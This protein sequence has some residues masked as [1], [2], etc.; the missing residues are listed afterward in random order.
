MGGFLT[1]KEKKEGALGKIALSSSSRSL[2][3]QNR[4]GD[5][6]GAPLGSG[7]PEY[8]GGREEGEKEEEAEG[9]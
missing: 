2:P 1:E 4:G 3:R 9:V 7:S 6:G 8:G 5:E